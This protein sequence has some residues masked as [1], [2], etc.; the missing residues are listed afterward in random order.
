MVSLSAL[1]NESQGSEGCA[2]SSLLLDPRQACMPQP[3]SG[4]PTYRNNHVRR[5]CPSNR[6]RRKQL[7]MLGRDRVGDTLDGAADALDLSVEGVQGIRSLRLGICIWW[8]VLKVQPRFRLVNGAGKALLYKHGCGD[9][10]C[11]GGIDTEERAKLVE[12]DVGVQL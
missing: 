2:R 5:S 9:P 7:R 8:Q 12:G 11:L 1:L 3:A 4:C 6:C 10:L